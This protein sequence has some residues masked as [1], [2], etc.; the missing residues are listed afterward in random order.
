MNQTIRQI[1][2]VSLPT[3]CPDHLCMEIKVSRNVY[4]GEKVGDPGKSM[5]LQYDIDAATNSAD[6]QSIGSFAL[7]ISSIKPS[8]KPTKH[9]SSDDFEF[10]ASIEVTAGSEEG[11]LVFTIEY[12]RVVL[13]QVEIR[14]EYD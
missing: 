14:Q 4:P 3:E 12:N 11:V 8:A 1:L 2:P 7:D 9:T 6:V 10:E 5:L 13:G